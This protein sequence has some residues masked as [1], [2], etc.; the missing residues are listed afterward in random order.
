M[1]WQTL[2]PRTAKEQ[3][4]IRW[5]VAEESQGASQFLRQNAR[6]HCAIRSRPNTR[7]TAA[8]VDIASLGTRSSRVSVYSIGVKIWQQI[9]RR[10]KCAQFRWVEFPAVRYTGYVDS[11][12][13]VL[14]QQ[15]SHRHQPSHPLLV[16]GAPLWAFVELEAVS[17]PW[18][19]WRVT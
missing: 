14:W 12:A 10:R 7:P 6:W 9:V 8:V 4:L 16:P 13:S 17:N 11:S 19:P 2:G 18:C 15:H 5:D 3:N 1:V